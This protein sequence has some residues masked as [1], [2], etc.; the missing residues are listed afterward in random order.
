[1]AIDT[2]V[3]SSRRALL[4][5]SVG[6]AAALAADALAGPLNAQAADG[7]RLTVGRTFTATRVTKITNDMTDA[8]VLAGISKTGIGV[9]GAGAIGVQGTS[10]EFDG[11]Q[12]VSTDGVGVAGYSTSGNGVLADSRSGLAL[13]ATSDTGFGV[14]GS[15]GLGGVQGVSDSGVGVVAQSYAGARA[16]L[17]EGY[18]L[19]AIGRLSLSTAGVATIRA[20][21]SSTRI[22]P[23]VDVAA[24]SFVLLTPAADIGSRRLWYTLNRRANTV[25]IRMSSTRSRPTKVSYLLLG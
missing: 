24:S 6:A 14:Y 16:P 22:T 23:G 15:G 2:H 18:A 5:G 19:Q 20:G 7:D 11:V 12:G 13:S 4:A 17:V 3:R 10:V 8:T 25:T 21:S 9:R 1:M